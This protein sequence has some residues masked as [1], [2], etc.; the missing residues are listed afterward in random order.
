MQK[1]T[2]FKHTN[3]NHGK[4]VWKL[5]LRISSTKIKCN[6]AVN[7]C[8]V[9]APFVEIEMVKEMCSVGWKKLKK[10]FCW[11]LDFWKLGN[12]T[13]SVRAKN[14]HNWQKCETTAH[15]KLIMSCLYNNLQIFNI[16]MADSLL[17]LF[18]LTFNAVFWF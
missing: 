14:L 2:L 3:V 12:C 9:S 11:L 15:C 10:F 17:F 13:F 8:V 7:F 4:M 16:K 5:N 18:H 6:F 1:Y